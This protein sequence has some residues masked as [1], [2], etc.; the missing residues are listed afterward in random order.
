MSEPNAYST[1][2]TYDAGM[3]RGDSRIHWSAVIAGIFAAM[4]AMAI[5]SVL[6][7]AV[8][9][10]AAEVRGYGG[11]A[12]GTGV[13]GVAVALISFCF[14]GWFAARVAGVHR[15]SNATLNG[16]M[17]WIVAI[18]LMLLFYSGTIGIAAASHRTDAAMTASDRYDSAM[19][20]SD[21]TTTTVDPAKLAWGTLVAML[22]GLGA[23]ALGGY[24]AT[25]TIHFNLNLHRNPHPYAGT[26]TYGTG[27]V[28]PSNPN[29]PSGTNPPGPVI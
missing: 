24:L 19:T 11:Y 10:T 21:R 14:G 29:N 22:L 27:Y 2:S 20:S 3:F 15:D 1:P 12:W 8:G 9:L 4:A 26:Q 7:L 6:G 25:G 18:P 16:V 23:A 13:W 5:L 17:V 28:P